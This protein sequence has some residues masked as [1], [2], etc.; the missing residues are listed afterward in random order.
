MKLI[1]DLCGT[2][3]RPPPGTPS[4]PG[5]SRKTSW[6]FPIVFTPLMPSRVVFTSKRALRIHPGLAQGFPS[7]SISSIPEKSRNHMEWCVRFPSRLW[8]SLKVVQLWKICPPHLGRHC[9]DVTSGW[10][11]TLLVRETCT[12]W[13]RQSA[14]SCF[15]RKSVCLSSHF[16]KAHQK[17]SQ[18]KP[19]RL[20]FQR[21]EDPS[22]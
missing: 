4:V 12:M 10:K 16:S 11:R 22:P 1:L 7:N 21:L 19:L 15:G 6:V 18:H 5:T 20:W 3:C 17:Q 13:S 14:T 8:R 9:A 2:P